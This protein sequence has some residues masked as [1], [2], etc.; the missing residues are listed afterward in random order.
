[1][2]KTNDDEFEFRRDY[3]RIALE[4]AW[5]AKRDKRRKKYCKWVRLAA[6]RFIRD[7][8]RAENDP[9]CSFY[10]DAWEANNPCDFIEQLPHVEGVWDD[11]TIVLEPWQIFNTVNMFGFRR[12]SDS[13]R[14]FNTVYLEVGRKNAKS[15][16]AAG[17]ALY[18]E[19]CE[20]ENGPQCFTAA[21]TGKQAR[22]VFNVAK[23][24]VERTSDLE[25]AFD[26]NPMASSIVC[27][28]NGGFLQPINS[29]ASTQD[30]LNPHFALL[31]E[32]HAHPN[33]ELFDVLKSAR[34]ARKNPFSVYIT[35]A[36]YNNL[37]VCYEQRTIV[38]KILEGVIKGDHYYGIIYTIDE[39]DDEFDENCWGKPNPNLDVSVQRDELRGYAEEARVSPDSLGE[40][41]TKRLNVWT[42]AKGAWINIH[43]WEKCGSKINV[44]DLRDVPCYAGL[45][46]A[47]TQDFNAFVLLWDIDGKIIVYPRFYLPEDIVKPRTERGN[48]PFQT[49]ADKGHILLT[50]GNVCDYAYIEKDIKEHLSKFNIQKIGYDEW[51]A[52]DLTN[53]LFE[54]DAPL[55]GFRQGPKS[56][57]PPMQ[58]FSRKYK[59]GTFQHGNNPV[60]NWM[61]SNLVARKDVNE[62]MAPDRKNSQ[63]K[64]DGM[65][66]MFMAWG[67]MLG[68]DEDD[69]PQVVVL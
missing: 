64:I 46:L 47:A 16:W 53:R 26:L 60:L 38:T 1:M 5:D 8:E 31:D 32:L 27:H 58:D 9:D 12:R 44:E 45:D 49:W 50:P 24:M 11:P 39:D 59:A 14:R 15:T 56:Y 21:T 40:F 33:R 30:G 67:L 57:H 55:E 6:I 52:T 10:F 62:N 17:I 65:V 28:E 20:G 23:K 54:D 66:A 7:L 3:V 69:V 48:V 36:G 63:E 22:I 29:K 13:F 18:C 61:A 41:K 51:N 34:G 35:T 42:T 68:Q 43:V 25:E 19:C 4:Y 37:G 2:E